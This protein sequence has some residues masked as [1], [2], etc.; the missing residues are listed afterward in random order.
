MS[1]CLHEFVTNFAL[2]KSDFFLSV[3]CRVRAVTLSL[4]A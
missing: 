3:L 4:F 2:D 1:A